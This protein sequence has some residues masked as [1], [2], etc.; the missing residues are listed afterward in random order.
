MVGEAA[1]DAKTPI[2]LLDQQDPNQSVGDGQLSEGEL[3]VGPVAQ[4]LRVAICRSDGEDQ[5]RPSAVHRVVF[6]QSPG[7]LVRGQDLA[8]FVEEHELR[9]QGE[10][11]DQRALT[12][13][14]T[15]L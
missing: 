2:D 7:K 10:G 14:F 3:A 12:G 9:T 15:D 8:A 5:W 13:V 1:D 6:E 4:G 11:A